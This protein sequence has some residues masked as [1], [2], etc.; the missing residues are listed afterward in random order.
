MG[1]IKRDPFKDPQQHEQEQ[2]RL[3]G[4][5]LPLPLADHLRLL[6]VYYGKSIQSILQELITEWMN[7]VNKPEKEVIDALVERAVV[8]WHRRIMEAGEISRQQQEEYIEEIKDTL[9][10]RRK[11]ADHHADKVVE[12]LKR[13]VGSIG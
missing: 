2:S 10:R 12:K 3:V 9:L 13:K 5:Y 8:E 4:A 11:L 7:T 1:E 6:S